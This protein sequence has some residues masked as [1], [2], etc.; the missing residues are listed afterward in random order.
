MGFCYRLGGG[1]PFR[2][3][4]VMVLILWVRIFPD[5]GKVRKLIMPAR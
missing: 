2:I 5:L 1:R 4:S 3:A